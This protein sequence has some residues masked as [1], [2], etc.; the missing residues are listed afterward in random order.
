ML[1]GLLP[2]GPSHMPGRPGQLVTEG[3]RPTKQRPVR[4]HV[5]SRLHLAHSFIG[6]RCC[7]PS[8][9]RDPVGAAPDYEKVSFVMVWAAPTG[10]R[11]LKAGGLKMWR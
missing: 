5:S 1:T 8:W 6:L 3:C 4:G 2:E 10:A 7:L 11:D 9:T